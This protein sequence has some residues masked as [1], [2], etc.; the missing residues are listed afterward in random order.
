MELTIYNVIGQAV[1]T[2]VS[3]PQNAG[4]Y[5]VEW[6]ATDDHGQSLSSGLYLYRLQAG[7]FAAVGK[8]VLLK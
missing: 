2:L 8:M 1:R 5:V 6:D 3:E 4:R 7:E